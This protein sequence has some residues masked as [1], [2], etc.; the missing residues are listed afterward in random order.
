MNPLLIPALLFSFFLFV[1]PA[2]KASPEDAT[3]FIDNLS[4]HVVTIVTDK[5][6]PSGEKEKTL[7]AMFK[8]SVDVAWIGKFVLGKYWRTAS[9][10]Q[11]ARYQ[12][13]YDPF[14]IRS[15]T[16][17]FREYSG[18]KSEALGAKE[19]KAGEY[20]VNTRI[21]RPNAAPILVDYRVRKMDGKNA[22]PP[23]RVF[24][25]IVEGVS[26]LA[27]QRSEFSAVIARDGMDSLIKQL[28]ARAAQFEKGT[29]SSAAAPGVLKSA[30]AAK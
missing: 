26:L 3:G 1:T 16:S 15:Y 22:K 17:R 9:E 10:D 25:V 23:Y 30:S 14:L 19:T 8:E 11:R 5:S 2:A 12:Q 28:E 24:D 4:A 7:E 6:I 21:I 27:T 18:E 13:F 20:I 29:P